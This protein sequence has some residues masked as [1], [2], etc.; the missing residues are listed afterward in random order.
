MKDGVYHVAFNSKSGA[1]GE[2]VL[3]VC[4][5]T[6]N[7]GDIGFVYQGILDRPEMTLRITRY[8]DDIPSV[9][10]MENDYELVMH[11]SHERGGQY[12]L[13]GY[14]MAY[15]QL[16]IEACATYLVPLLMIKHT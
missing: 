12:M 2:G 14:A 8:Q 11:Y 4:C 16:T 10:G 13:H 3:V 9:L 1:T 7:G 6:I 15:P 5:G